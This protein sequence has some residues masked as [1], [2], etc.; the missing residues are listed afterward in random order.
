MPN[1]GVDDWTF[2]TQKSASSYFLLLA[3][4]GQIS[5]NISVSVVPPT[6]PT[7]LV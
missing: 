3:Q 2:P 5:L 6:C 4:P 1:F 7:Q